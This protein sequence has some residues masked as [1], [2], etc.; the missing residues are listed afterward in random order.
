[1]STTPIWLNKS[2]A[3]TYLHRLHEVTVKT[4]NLKQNRP[5]FQ[6]LIN[7]NIRNPNSGSA[8]ASGRP[9]GN[10]AKFGSIPHIRINNRPMFSR[11]HLKEWFI[12]CYLPTMKAK[13]Q[14]AA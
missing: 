14:K 13:S 1:M 7:E 6:S 10:K 11:Q 2:E 12:K 4:F 5:N 9:R 8:I 3:A